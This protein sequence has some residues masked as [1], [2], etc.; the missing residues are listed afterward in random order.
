MNVMNFGERKPSDPLLFSGADDD[1]TLDNLLGPD[2]DEFGDGLSDINLDSL[3]HQDLGH[4]LQNSSL[5]NLV[6]TLDEQENSLS[7]ENVLQINHEGMATNQPSHN[8]SI[9]ILQQIQTPIK[10]IAQPSKQKLD[11]SDIDTI[12]GAVM[13]L[14]ANCSDLDKMKTVFM[15][16]DESKGI[17]FVALPV[18]VTRTNSTNTTPI[19]SPLKATAI[20]LENGVALSIAETTYIHSPH[21][22]HPLTFSTNGEKSQHILSPSQCSPL[23]L[24]HLQSAFVTQRPATVTLGSPMKQPHMLQQL[25]HQSDAQ[26]TV[27]S[28]QPAHGSCKIKQQDWSYPKP[29]FSY[30]CLIALALKNSNAG[31]LPVSEIYN[32]M[33]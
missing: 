9:K 13:R 21:K 10:C 12:N 5:S 18:S 24:G 25:I 6:T 8:Y 19:N 16:T 31:N 27:T 14:H 4:W 32:F 11:V 3:D 15:Q 23:L 29:V 28:S 33:W 26:Q 17:Q 2:R 22:L 30:S 1:K 7:D 20:I